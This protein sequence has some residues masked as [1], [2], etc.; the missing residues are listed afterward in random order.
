[1]GVFNMIFLLRLYP[2]FSMRHLEGLA[3]HDQCNVV[4][5][6]EKKAARHAREQ[7]YTAYQGPKW[8]GSTRRPQPERIG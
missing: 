1:V 2:L 4:D 7:R 6:L 3:I 8:I 5:C